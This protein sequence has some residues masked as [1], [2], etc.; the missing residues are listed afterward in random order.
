MPNLI[1]QPTQYIPLPGVFN[2]SPE[3]AVTVA[4]ADLQS[5]GELLA[6]SLRTATGFPLPVRVGESGAL[7]LALI[8]DPD[9]GPEG[10]RLEV[11][12]EGI[13][14]QAPHP[15]GLFYAIQTLR[16]LLPPESSPT[17]IQACQI[18]DQPT[19]R[20]RGVMLDVA[21]H[22]FGMADLKRL[23]DLAAGYKC[24]VLHLHLSDDQGW[25]LAINAWPRLAEY[26]GS[27][28][29]N[30][31]PGGF[32]TQPEYQELVAYAQSRQM[33][34][35]PEI[36]MP[37]HT[38]AAIISYPELKGT[39]KS[40][41]LYTGAEVGFSSLAIHEK[42]TYKFLAEVLG[43]LATLTPGPYLHIG[44]D[45]AHSTPE[46][47][48]KTFIERLQP[49]VRSLGKTPIG[50]EEVGKADLDPATV[51]QYWWNAD[52]ASRA[53]AQG[54]PLIMSPARKVYLDIKYDP[55]IRLGQDWTQSYID[56]RDSYDWDPL[57]ILPEAK[58][59]QI[60]GI[61]ALLWTETTATRDD[62]D[63]MIFPR[64]CAVAE[65]GWTPSGQR[66]W[67]DFRIRLSA[68]GPRLEA[69]GVK[70]YR[71]PQIPWQA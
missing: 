37:G 49:I 43:E 3:T 52:F 10:Y 15:T 1:P 33:L 30:G 6:A 65:V 45:E 35:V 11:Y 20:W 64:L 60:L 25:R 55:T 4:V 68:H 21:R 29:S 56:V 53:A 57:T 62:V 9:L 47:E 38:H 34:L 14:L 70:F 27:S 67:N 12:P 71:S 18:R 24:N 54:N 2:L 16:Q 8:S 19:F 32:Y 17:I 51:V 26:G 48:Y 63:F 7:H 69:L 22:F 5:L 31:A 23:I 39:T 58:S 46:P 36:D 42:I 13:S 66:R 61:E 59:D 40:D 28:A 50:W 41:E 44:G